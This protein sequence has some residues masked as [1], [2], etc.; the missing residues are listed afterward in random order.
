MASVNEDLRVGA[1]IAEKM[2]ADSSRRQHK[3]GNMRTYQAPLPVDD[4]TQKS[5][6]PRSQRKNQA[7]DLS[8]QQKRARE[9]EAEESIAAPVQFNRTALESEF[10]RWLLCTGQPGS[11]KTT[12]VRSISSSIASAKNVV[13]MSGF[14]T[15]EVLD[16]AGGRIGFD[17]VTIPEGRRSVLSRKSG[18][19]ASFPKVGAY[20]VDVASFE[21]LA[22]PSIAPSRV[23]AGGLIVI[24]EIGR[25]ELKS[26]AFQ[27]AIEGLLADQS[28]RVLG[29]LTAPIYG[30]RVP[31]CDV[32]ASQPFVTVERITAKTRDGVREEMERAVRKLVGAE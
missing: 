3:G 13:P 23:P 16:N 18:L 5:S 4:G 25:M 11:G 6:T 30:H 17:V 7:R 14:Y 8:R 20:S 26:E 24:D 10:S 15:D 12:L 27:R 28:T 2:G 22:L 19:P 21:G 1:E 32:V 9:Q 29:A 31:F